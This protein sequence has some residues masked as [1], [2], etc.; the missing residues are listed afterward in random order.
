M[1]NLD[2]A[3]YKWYRG[4]CKVGSSAW[5]VAT[6]H[7]SSGYQARGWAPK[8]AVQLYRRVGHLLLLT[9]R[10]WCLLHVN[11]GI[12]YLTNL[13][14]PIISASIVHQVVTIGLQDRSDSNIHQEMWAVQKPYIFLALCFR[15]KYIFWSV[16]WEQ[17]LHYKLHN[18]KWRIEQK[19]HNKHF[20]IPDTCRM[21]RL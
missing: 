19:K 13:S 10:W 2:W 6:L 12:S 20:G 18:D 7:L 9:Y 21:Q 1:C 8:A 14:C 11:S 17:V 15:I 3:G 5:H 16:A 4:G